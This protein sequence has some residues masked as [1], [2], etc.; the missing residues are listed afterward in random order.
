MFSPNENMNKS[1]FVVAL[2]R[3]FEWKH[4]NENVSPRWQNYFNEA[5]SLWLVGPSDAVTFDTPISRY[6]VALFL[7]KFDIKYKMLNNLNNNR[8]L[9]EVV[10]TV[11][12]SITTWTN[13]KLQANV[14][15]DAN[16]LKDGDFDV[17]YVEI[18]GTRYKVVKTSEETYF[19]DNFVWYGDVFDMVTDQKLWSSNFM[20]SNWYVIESTI[21]FSAWQNYKITWIDWTNAYYQINEK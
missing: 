15:V 17:W 6:E 16:L 3:M 11:W 2:I 14:Y 18:F 4:L 10:S 21:R 9:N 8:I 1:Q 12:W 7:Y 5:Q 20:V 13:W 19:T